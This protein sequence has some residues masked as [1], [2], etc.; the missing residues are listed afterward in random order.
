MVFF[1]TDKIS[2]ANIV[3]KK[4]WLF[5][6]QAFYSEN[7][8]RMLLYLRLVIFPFSIFVTDIYHR[9]L[10]CKSHHASRIVENNTTYAMWEMIGNRCAI[11]YTVL[12][13]D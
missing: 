5:L 8:E 12:L 13:I 10:F 1:K 6:S 2:C 3:L 7:I 9:R 11:G 4:I